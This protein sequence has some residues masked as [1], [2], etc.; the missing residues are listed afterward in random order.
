VLTGSEQI[1]RLRR[2][3]VAV[4]GD[5]MVDRFIWGRVARISPEAPVPVVE[6]DRSRESDGFRLGGAANVANN[7]VQLGARAALYGVVGEDEAARQFW[8]LLASRGIDGSGIR[9]VSERPTTLKTRVIAHAQQVVRFDVEDRSPLSGATLEGLYR[10]LIDHLDRFDALILSDYA[11]GVIDPARLPGLIRALRTAGKV[12]AVDPKV[13]NVLAYAG[14]TVVTPNR[15]EACSAAGI[16]VDA[17]DAARRAGM[18]LLEHLRCE[19]VLVTLGE[20]GMLLLRAGQP[21]LSVPAQAAEVFDVT[22]AGDTVI[23]VLT[24]ALAVGLDWL[25]AV[26][27]ANAAAGVVVGKIGTAAVTGSELERALERPL[28]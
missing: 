3:R 18:W 10:A 28:R 2:A 4:L 20:D 22:G 9:V 7:L 17:P 19:A 15:L 12:V 1:E 16:P 23:A 14:V 13:H 8:R 24:A 26:R 11:K 5:V 27:L 21:E 6:V 25:E